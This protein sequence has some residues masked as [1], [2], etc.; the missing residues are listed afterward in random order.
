MVFQ[1]KPLNFP[2]LITKTWEGVYLIKTPV[3]DVSRKN[4]EELIELCSLRNW[5]KP[6]QLDGQWQCSQRTTRVF[7]VPFSPQIHMKEFLQILKDSLSNCL[8]PQIV[9]PS[10][11]CFSKSQESN[12]L[13][14]FLHLRLEPSP[15][16]LTEE[17]F[18][19]SSETSYLWAELGGVSG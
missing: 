19:P 16:L 10:T 12:N 7:V 4:N 18:S 8:I 15:W 11:H 5:R 14:V 17:H 9:P 2:T 3:H 13:R 6:L 1:I